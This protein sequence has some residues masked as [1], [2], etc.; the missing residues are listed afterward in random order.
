MAC[1]TQWH[2]TLTDNALHSSVHTFPISASSN[3]NPTYLSWRKTIHEQQTESYD[4]TVLRSCIAK[5]TEDLQPPQRYTVARL[6]PGWK[7]QG[8]RKGPLE[9]A[10]ADEVVMTRLQVAEPFRTSTTLFVSRLQQA[11]YKQQRFT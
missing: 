4:L 10:P 3:A 6:G 7:G 11:Q 8:G 2:I 1:V 9:R 5:G